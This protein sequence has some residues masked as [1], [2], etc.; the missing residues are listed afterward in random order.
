MAWTDELD[1]DALLR[2]MVVAAA[3]AVPSGVIGAVSQNAVFVVLV[4]AGLIAGAAVA[5]TRQTK[6]TPLTHGI[7][8][9]VAVFVAVQAVGTARRAIAGDEIRWG[10]IFSSALLSVMAG[11]IGGFIGGVRQRARNGR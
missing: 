6:R 8:A 2:G 3:I 1:R 10:R 7:V 5:G 11:T 9:A 4:I